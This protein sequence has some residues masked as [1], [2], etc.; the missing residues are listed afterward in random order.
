MKKTYSFIL[1]FLLLSS[2]SFAQ[3][4]KK[5]FVYFT[6]KNNSSFST[7]RPEEFLSQRAIERRQNRTPQI[8]ITEKDF[9]VNADY[10]A[11]LTAAG[12]DLWYTSKWMNAA[13]VDA[14]E[15]TLEE[16][17]SLPFVAKTEL[18]TKNSGQSKKYPD[19]I[20]DQEYKTIDTKIENL[21]D[22]GA[23]LNQTQQLGA[24]KMHEE[25][26]RGEGMIIAIFDSGFQNVHKLSIFEHIFA[27]NRILGTFNFVDFNEY[28]FGTGSHGT[29]VFSCIGA[30]EKGRM[31][32]TAPDAQFYLFRT[33]DASTE[34]R[35]EEVNW[36][37]AAERADSLGVDVINSSLGYNS[38]DDKSMDY[39]ISDMDG[40]TALITRAA[41]MAVGTGMIVVTS[42]GNSGNDSW[43]YIT[44][45]ADA[46]SVIAVGAVD[47]YGDYVNFSSK[48]YTSDGRLKPNLAAKGLGST[49]GGTGGS[50]KTA[51]GTSFASPIL[52]GFVASFWQANPELN[53]M[54]LM[55]YLQLSGNQASK[56][57]SLLGNGVPDYERAQEAVQNQVLKGTGSIFNPELFPNP[58]EPNNPLQI[59][60]GNILN[61]RDLN[62]NVLNNKGQTL[63]RNYIPEPSFIV[64]LPEI[65]TLN[66]GTYLMKMTSNKGEVTKRFMKM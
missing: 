46:D 15:T 60:L 7:D 50:I 17:K 3:K 36:L 23:A 32:G 66:A 9:P 40:N 35:V 43:Q 19:F 59:N 5:Y 34:F 21:Q 37:I 11:A 39:E 61:I 62:I 51:S 54:E 49:V 63:I 8:A 1:A 53:N 47:R 22:Y 10:I 4:T 48:G 2:I 28:V 44:A 38:F 27:S 29:Q 16:I 42:A 65:S 18:L 55:E 12:A 52:C 6:D 33:E 45:P 58:L 57:D 26:Y 13:M 20:N 31:I 56:P 24:E 14:S 41:D 64:E 25:G 30:F